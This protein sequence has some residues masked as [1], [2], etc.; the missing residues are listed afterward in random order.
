[1]A[2]EPGASGPEPSLYFLDAESGDEVV[3]VEGAVRQVAERDE[4]ARFVE[5]DPSRPSALKAAS[6]RVDTR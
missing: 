2:G 1:V 6:R 5:T 3:V 4:L